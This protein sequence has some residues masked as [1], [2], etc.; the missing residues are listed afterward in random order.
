MRIERTEAIVLHTIAVRERDKMVVFLTPDR[1]KVKGW[2]YG[3]RAIRSRFG[4]SLE[5]L[6]KVNIGYA[7]KES[8]N[9]VRIESVDL[10]RSLFPAQQNL[11]G[12]VAA[13]FIAEMMDTFAPEHDPAELMYRLLDRTTEALLDGLP[14]MP[15]V[16]YAEVWILRLGGILPSLRNCM[17]CGAPLARPLRFDPR[18]EGFVCEACASRE[19]FIVPNAVAD[20]I[21]AI[22]RLPVADFALRSSST[23]TL[24][25]V[26]SLAG[27]LRRN[28]LGHELKSFEV[29][30]SVI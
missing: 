26:R 1:G 5:P 25:E 7:E 30:A 12:S 14:P 11:L 23:E 27:T 13:T 22:L 6:S 19:T 10:L 16:A 17:Q 21:D 4:A 8:E 24:F 15:V 29:L 9:V 3:A 2:A 18:L 28:F 20:E